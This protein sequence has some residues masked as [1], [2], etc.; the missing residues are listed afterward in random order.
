MGG[1]GVIWESPCT[2]ILSPL[3]SVYWN[4]VPPDFCALKFCP[5]PNQMGGK[6]KLIFLW[7]FW[8]QI[9]YLTPVMPIRTGSHEN[10]LN[11]R[12]WHRFTFCSTKDVTEMRLPRKK[13]CPEIFKCSICN[14]FWTFWGYPLLRYSHS[15]CVTFLRLP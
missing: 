6:L 11:P 13:N 8:S 15:K 7:S 5:P 1:G 3:I 10:G 9:G 4:F 2:E 12:N 14:F